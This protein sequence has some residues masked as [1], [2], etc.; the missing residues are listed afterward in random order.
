MPQKNERVGN[1]AAIQSH[2]KLS[3]YMISTNL[4]T[5]GPLIFVL[6][7]NKDTIFKETFCLH[8]DFCPLADEFSQDLMQEICHNFAGVLQQKNKNKLK[9]QAALNGA[10]AHPCPSG[11]AAVRDK[12]CENDGPTS[13]R[14][15]L[16]GPSRGRYVCE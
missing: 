8:G 13:L 3:F 10:L 5:G 12:D 6:D 14:G 15:L 9:L 2:Y 4:H 16:P 7:N 11:S 1:T